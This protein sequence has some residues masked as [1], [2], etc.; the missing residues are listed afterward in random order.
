MRIFWELL[1]KKNYLMNLEQLNR[2]IH[3]SLN[4]IW[5]YLIAMQLAR[6]LLPFERNMEAD[7]S[8]EVNSRPASRVEYIRFTSSFLLCK[9]GEICRDVAV[10]VLFPARAVINARPLCLCAACRHRLIKSQ[11]II[12]LADVNWVSPVVFFY[13]RMSR[14]VVRRHKNIARIEERRET[15]II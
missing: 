14:R 6:L 7:C 11:L 2:E 9:C 13:Y 8:S 5:W 1:T 10:L 4:N 3:R 15:D 12:C